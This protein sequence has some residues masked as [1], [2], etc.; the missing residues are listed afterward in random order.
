MANY[1]FIYYACFWGKRNRAFFINASKCLIDALNASHNGE[2]VPRRMIFT[3]YHHSDIV[4]LSAPASERNKQPILEVIQQYIDQRPRKLLELGSGTGQHVVHFAPHFPNTIFQPSDIDIPSLNSIAA[5]I[6]HYKPPNV[7][8][9]LHIDVS[10]GVHSWTLPDGFVQQEIDVLL[11][12]NMIHISSGAAVDGLFKA[13]GELLKPGSGLL[14]TYGAYAI[15]GLITPQS[16]IDFD[17]SLRA[18]NPEWGLRDI[19]E[20]KNKAIANGLELTNIHDMPA[21]N[22]TLIFRRNIV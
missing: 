19:N 17:K 11:N 10:K 7:L 20:L 9:P 8:P 15:N 4:M 12:I 13:A 1:R 18:R 16:N 14:I 3:T 6:Q 21:N 22:K 2:I 5:Y